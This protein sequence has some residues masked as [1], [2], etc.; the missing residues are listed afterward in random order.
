M[1]RLWKAPLAMPVPAYIRATQ[2]VVLR[3]DA[4]THHAEVYLNSGY[5]TNVCYHALIARG[6]SVASSAA[7]SASR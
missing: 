5:I 3:F 2:R 4:V 6:A 1:R 7:N